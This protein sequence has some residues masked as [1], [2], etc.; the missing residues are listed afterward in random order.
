MYFFQNFQP[1]SN[2]KICP[3]NMFVPTVSTPKL[4]SHLRSL[5]T[6]ERC[7]VRI[8]GSAKQSSYPAEDTVK[9]HGFRDTTPEVFFVFF[10]GQFFE[11]FL[12]HVGS[13]LVGLGVKHHLFSSGFVYALEV[14]EISQTIRGWFCSDDPWIIRIPDPRGLQRLFDLDFLGI[15]HPLSIRKPLFEAFQGVILRT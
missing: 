13:I 8:V 9:L 6:R 14:R 5:P 3:S 1:F 7:E 11:A 2:K 15:Y 10:G 12:H 4:G